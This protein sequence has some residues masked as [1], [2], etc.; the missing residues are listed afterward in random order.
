MPQF[1][2]RETERGKRQ[3]DRQTDRYTDTQIEWVY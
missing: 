2:P 3:T 1:G